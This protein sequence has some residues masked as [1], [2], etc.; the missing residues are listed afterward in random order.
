[1]ERVG[2]LRARMREENLDAVLITH[3]SNR[4]WLSGFTAG[5]IPPNESAGSL[6]I[7]GDVAYVIT[8]ALN[9][10]GAAEQATGFEVIT[11]TRAEPMP[12]HVA[13]LLQE[14]GG[15]R[16]GF[17]EGATLV[18]VYNALGETTEG[19]VELVPV[20]EMA[21][22]LR[23]VKSPDEISRIERAARITDEAFTAVR[24][25]MRPEQTEREVAW[26]LEVAMRERGAEGLAFPV[27]VAAGPN[28]ARP[29]H[30]PGDHPL[31]EGLPI[32][33]DMGAVVDGYA[34]DLTRTVVL[35]E[36]TERTREVYGA[37]LRAL[38]LAEEGLR[39]GM[40][41]AEADA[42][43]REPIVAAGFGDYFPHGLGHGVGVRVHEAP[44]AHKEAEA[45]LPAGATLTIEPGI[46]IPDWGG[47]RIEDLVVIEPDGVRVL[48]HAKIERY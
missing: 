14:R 36:P 13:R 38:D 5:D 45:A 11:A 33:I 48:S 29:H 42:L 22:E 31:G 10:E 35:G 46:Y 47:V 3:P 41:G 24:R 1:M 2:R 6:L 21:S 20:G 32:T 37:V 26:A 23:L 25:T 17:E 12:K 34:A 28:G 43:A 8:S 19:A 39:A 4:F 44:G 27:I 18:S 40:T 15:R 30:E 7:T 9:A 16:L